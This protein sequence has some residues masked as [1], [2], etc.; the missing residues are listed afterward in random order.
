MLKDLQVDEGQ[1]KIIYLKKSTST[2]RDLK[3]R[4]G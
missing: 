2:K 3:N 4:L 1:Y